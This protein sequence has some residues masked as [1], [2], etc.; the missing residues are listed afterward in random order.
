VPLLILAREESEEALARLELLKQSR[1]FAHAPPRVIGVSTLREAWKALHAPQGEELPE[2]K[3]TLKPPAEPEHEVRLL[4]IPQFL[5]RLLGV[6]AAGGHHLLMLGP[7][8]TGKSQALEWWIALQ[9]PPDLSQILDQLL[10]QETPVSQNFAR[11]PVRRVGSQAR[12][13]ALIGSLRPG[14]L[15]PGEFTLAHGGV[16]IA[17]ELPEWSRDAR[18]ALREPLER[19][20]VTLTRTEG[21]VELPADFRLGATGNLCPCGGWKGAHLPANQ[22]RG[23]IC[24]DTA[25]KNYLKRI[26]G[27]VLDRID[28]VA[29]LAEG[30][31]PLPSDVPE[32]RAVE[33]ATSAFR[34]LRER[35]LL[36]HQH[37]CA[38]WGAPAGRLSAATT[39]ELLGGHAATAQALASLNCD[40]LRARHKILRV[41]MTL[42]AWEGQDFPG[43][44]HLAEARLYR[45]ERFV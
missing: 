1:T 11:A 34:A 4:P 19:A 36:T 7:K 28:L 42:A 9:P 44:E 43:P 37:A 17:D 41:A 33:T 20:V 22:E 31:L 27:P 3:S 26:S 39:E 6:A 38:R 18:E 25:R 16:L 35:V 24:K 30:T 40:S 32:T 10:L 2:R 14:K 5:Q 8:G 21:S 15:R 45:P 12:C 23:C 13:A 29:R